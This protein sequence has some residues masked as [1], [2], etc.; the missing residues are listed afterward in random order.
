MMTSPREPQEV[1]THLCGS[2]RGSQC[3]LLEEPSAHM[4]PKSK[5]VHSLLHS[6]SISLFLRKIIRDNQISRNMN[7]HYLF[8]S[9]QNIEINPNPTVD[10]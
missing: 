5:N 6:N 9:E 3:R 7:I 2:Q 8:A 1:D 4:N 10:E